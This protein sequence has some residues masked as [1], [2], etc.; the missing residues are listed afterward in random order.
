MRANFVDTL[1]A[2]LDGEVATIW[3]TVLLRLEERPDV[4]ALRQ[5]LRALVR[6]SE[7]L[8]V[9]WD[10]A[11]CEWVPVA[12]PSAEVDAAVLETSEPL[13]EQEAVARVINTRMD[14]AR[15]LP[16][17]FHLHPMKDASQG[18]W[19]LG[20]QLHHAIGDA[21]ALGHLLERLWLHCA[22][23]ASESSP[24]APSRLTDGRVLLAALRRPEQLLG[25][26]SPRRRLLAP[27]GMGLKRSGDVAGP[28]LMT[29]VRLRIPAGRSDLVPSDVFFA[30]LLAGVALHEPRKEGRVRLRMPVDLRRSLGLGRIL[31]NGCSAVPIELPLSEVRARLE[32]PQGLIQLARSEIQ[33]VLD[34]G[35]H[36]TTAL[37]CMAVARLAPSQVLRRNARPGLLAE[38]RTNT[39]VV[40]Y[41]GRL[42]RHFEQSPLRIRSLRSHTPTWGATGFSFGETLC[43]NPATFEGLWSRDALRGFTERLAGWASSALSLPVEVVGP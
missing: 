40:T 19:M 43:I 6:E 14:L 10:D 37:E 21:K 9:A 12:R 23:R 38:P 36:W 24:L 41:L 32:D 2:R 34:A 11:R 15:E 5:G 13:D 7:R 35:I 42:D 26:A 25:L 22:G 17:R 39:L 18:A 29:T 8:N 1:M 28:S 31:G 33:R 20:V 27:R 30:A 3:A 4:A 16:L